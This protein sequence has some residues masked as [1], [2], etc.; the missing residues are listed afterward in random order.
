MRWVVNA[1][2][3]PL[4]PRKRPGTRCIGCWADPRAVL[5]RCGKYRPPLGLDVQTGQSVA[6]RCTDF[7]IP[8][9]FLNV[10]G[11]LKYFISLLDLFRIGHFSC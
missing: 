7:V 2:L 3:R 6:S 1:T 8:A 9:P 5:D 10:W 4:Y 11:G